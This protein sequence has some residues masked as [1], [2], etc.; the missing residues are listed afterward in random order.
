MK[1]STRFI[2]FMLVGLAAL[3]LYLHFRKPVFEKLQQEVRTMQAEESEMRI[4]NMEMEELTNRYSVKAD[5]PGFIEE[6]YRF[7]DQAVIE[8]HQVTTRGK[9]GP[10]RQQ[11][12]A[13]GRNK[14]VAGLDITRLEVVGHGTFRNIAEYLRLV[15]AAD[16]PKRII[17]MRIVPGQDSLQLN[18]VLEL[19]SYKG[20]DGA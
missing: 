12:P 8:D 6:L 2:V 10:V 1:N 19:Y 15:Q 7:A 11:V 14:T 16:S 4:A 13:A 9:Q 5:V 3:A 17:E 20:S 18:M